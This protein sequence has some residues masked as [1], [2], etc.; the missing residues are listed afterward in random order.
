MYEQELR[1]AIHPFKQIVI[2][3]ALTIILTLCVGLVAPLLSNHQHLLQSLSQILVFGLG[4]MVFTIWFYKTPLR[5]LQVDLRPVKHK[6]QWF[7]WAVIIMFIATPAVDFVTQ[8]NKNLHLPE[9]WS[10]WEVA[11]RQADM[12]SQ[13]YLTSLLETKNLSGLSLNFFVFAILPALCEELFFRGVLQQILYRWIKNIH[14]SVWITGFIFSLFHL[15]MLGFFPRWILGVILG[16]L[17]AFSCT[18][19]MPVIAHFLNNA[20]VVVF[21]YLYSTQVISI[22][23]NEISFSTSIPIVIISAIATVFILIQCCFLHTSNTE[24]Q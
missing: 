1:Y 5:L 9:V 13:A 4:S 16:Y 19:W 15:Q 2:L 14:F 23:P 24:Q 21:H 12:K 7:L 18:L 22:P 8:W 11:I 6:T 10:M 3:F 20:I 17:F